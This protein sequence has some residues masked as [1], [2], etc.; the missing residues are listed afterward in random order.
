[1]IV[2]FVVVFRNIFVKP[3]VSGTMETHDDDFTLM[4]NFHTLQTHLRIDCARFLGKVLQN[5][6]LDIDSLKES[7]TFGLLCVESQAEILKRNSFV[8]SLPVLC[9]VLLKCQYEKVN[10]NESVSFLPPSSVQPFTDDIVLLDTIW[11]RYIIDNDNQMISLDDMQNLREM[12]ESIGNR[13]ANRF[14]NL[15]EEYVKTIQRFRSQCKLFFSL[16]NV[17]T[18]LKSISI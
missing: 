16:Q 18:I 17:L 7:G 1:M 11:K 9:D 2:A 8:L 6:H 12:F 15:G 14:S 5:R 3:D 10:D 13:M 4:D